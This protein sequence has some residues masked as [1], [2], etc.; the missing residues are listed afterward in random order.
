MSES[1]R[2]LSSRVFL[3]LVVASDHAWRCQKVSVTELK[4]QAFA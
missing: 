3:C 1:D 2:Q 4:T